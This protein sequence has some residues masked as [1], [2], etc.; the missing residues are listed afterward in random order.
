MNHLLFSFVLFVIFPFVPLVFCCCYFP[1]FF[2]IFLH[3]FSWCLFRRPSS[4]PPLL[5]PRPLVSPLSSL[6]SFSLCASCMCVNKPECYRGF[7]PV[8]GVPL[9]GCHGNAWLLSRPLPPP[10]FYDL[11]ARSLWRR[12]GGR[13][14]CPASGFLFLTSSL[15]AVCLSVPC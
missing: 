3:V 6:S 12:G 13:L 2:L 8:V 4:A 7:L 14:I 1:L 9:R 10:S 11:Y 5:S 15:D